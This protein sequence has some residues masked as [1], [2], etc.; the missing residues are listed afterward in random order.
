MGTSI[1]GD[2]DSD[3]Q[4]QQTL[5]FDRLNTVQYCFD[6]LMDNRIESIPKNCLEQRL[7]KELFF[8]FNSAEGA[9]LIERIQGKP[10]S[11]FATVLRGLNHFSVQFYRTTAPHLS[12]P[13]LNT[14]MSPGQFIEIHCYLEINE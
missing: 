8:W 3:Y 13:F 4:M 2:V 1:T 11:A 14:L 5:G 10:H 7:K 6:Q 9:C 12:E